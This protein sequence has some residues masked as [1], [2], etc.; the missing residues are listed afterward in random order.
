MTHH[1]ECV[2]LEKTGS[3][4]APRPGGSAGY[5]RPMPSGTRDAAGILVGDAGALRIAAL[6]LGAKEAGLPNADPITGHSLRAEHATAAHRAGIPIARIAA[7]TRHKD[8]FAPFDCY[9]RPVDARELSSSR[10][11][12]G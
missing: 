1:V 8:L 9:A 11:L 6:A 10:N 4:W 2:A 3:E 7:Q 5:E 12:G